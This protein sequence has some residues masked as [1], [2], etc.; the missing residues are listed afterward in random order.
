MKHDK[1]VIVLQAYERVHDKNYS[2]TCA[3]SQDSDQSVHL[4]SLIR[5]FADHMCLLQ[6]PGYPKRD[7]GEQLPYWVDVQADLNFSC[8]LL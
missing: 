5:V 6:S 2:K 3:I 8:N 4:C 1:S 7:K